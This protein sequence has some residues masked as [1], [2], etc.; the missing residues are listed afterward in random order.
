MLS[1]LTSLLLISAVTSFAAV[2]RIEVLQRAD[3]PVAGYERIAGK[4]HFTLDPRLPAN[5]QIV[6]LAL[7]PKNAQGMVEFAADFQVLRAKDPAKSNGTLL[8]GIANR[9]T[10]SIWTSLNAGSN[11]AMTTAKDFGD[12]F[13]LSQGYT[14]AWVG[15]EWDVPQQPNLFKVYAPVVPN[16]TGPV[17]IEVLPNNKQTSEPL[18]YPVAD[19]SSGTFTV[20]DAP[21]APRQEL[22]KSAWRYSAD[23]SKVEF[24]TP[25]TP[26]RIY[27]FVYKGKDPVVSGTGFA[28]VRDYVSYVKKNGVV[29][30]ST[31]PIQRA[32]GFGI[33]QSGRVLR[34]MMYEGFNADEQGKQVFEGV[35][36]H[37]SGGGHGGFNQRFAQPTKTT[38]QYS[39][40]FYPTDQAPFAPGALLAKAGE[41]G[42]AP[43]MILTNGSHEYWGR[44]GVLNHITEDGSKDLDPPANVRLYFIAGIQHSGAGGVVNPLVQNVTNSLEVMYVLRA[45][46]LNLNA[47]VTHNTAPPPT[48]VP[49]MD[50][51][52]LVPISAL[53]F[54][55]I[56]NFGMV[57]YAYA[58][59]HFDWG[60][61]YVTKGIVAWEPGH[62]GG[63]YPVLVPQIDAD[64]NDVGG[65]R[66]PE[67]VHPLMTYTGW[68]PRNPSVGA[69]DQQY[70]LIGSQA[71]FA[72][73]KQ[74]RERTGDTRLSVS[75]RY[76]GKSEYVSK[77]EATAHQLVQQRFL[78]EVD[79][80]RTVNL[81]SRHWDEIM[82]P[83]T[84]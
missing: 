44:A 26:G 29:G 5:K 19:P 51:N 38:G 57:S 63:S 84:K 41:A 48:N 73:T 69:P 62:P 74:E 31:T 67:L 83:S 10:V 53:K 17:R 20:R 80:P 59:R 60:P 52:Q 76:R 32:V 24:T 39:G 34:T 13:L 11:S 75:E 18:P 30:T 15:W 1:R 49:R 54:P 81:A 64:G 2:S 3:L 27:E 72:R 37:V 58:P 50:K 36:A 82:N 40:S 65:V 79:V 45:T 28:A 55:Y 4:L 35:W 43:K 8:L 9:G 33:S 47:W 16:V 66:M 23:H 77:V 14:V 61:D 71:P 6:D 25:L 56:P 21:Y 70:S 68:N 22:P 12:N 42:V 78:L 46:L 7:A